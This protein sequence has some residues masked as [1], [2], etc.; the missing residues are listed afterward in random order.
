[1]AQVQSPGA[2]GSRAEE[3]TKRE[4]L[5]PALEGFLSGKMLPG[6]SR[7]QVSLAQVTQSREQA[8]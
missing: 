7:P 4:V 3:T 6:V 2:Q 8:L 5:D 1:M